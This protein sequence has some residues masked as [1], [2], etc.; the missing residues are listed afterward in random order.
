M[1]SEVNGPVFLVGCSRSGTTLLRLMLTCHP[2]ICI[3]PESTFLVRLHGRW[4]A[5]GIAGPEAVRAICEDL[6]ACDKKIADWGLDVNALAEALASQT[7]ISYRQFVEAVYRQYC[8]LTDPRAARWGDKNP[9]YVR[10]IDLV[11]SVFPEA[12]FIHILRDGR[13]VYNSFISANAKHG[14][15]YPEHPAD[16]AAHWRMSVR[17][18][19]RHRG[20]RYY[21]EVR[22]ESLITDPETVLRGICRFLGIQEAI[23][24]MM[25][26][27]AENQAR[28][29]V[30]AQRLAWHSATLRAPDSARGESWRRELGAWR[31]GVFELCA[32]ADLRALGYATR[33]PLSSLATVNRVASRLSR[34][35]VQASGR[36]GGVPAGTIGP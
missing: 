35:F 17:A 34:R 30:P 13:A 20:Q 6:V 27:P 31:A 11:R 22:Y 28:E 3:P 19:T 25:A 26:Y 29:L 14:R 23:D 15:V 21:H 36:S 1:L 12:R 10:N 9:E 4:G 32:G 33:I 18:G 5:S 16:A 2:D 24:A 7:P 8:A